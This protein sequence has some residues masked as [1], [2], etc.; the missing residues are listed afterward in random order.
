MTQ[1]AEATGREERATRIVREENRRVDPRNAG[2]SGLRREALDKRP[3]D[4]AAAKPQVDAEVQMS[5]ER[6]AQHTLIASAG[7]ATSESVQR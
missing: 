2:P 4:A 7:S 1:L 5:G 6:P 3:T